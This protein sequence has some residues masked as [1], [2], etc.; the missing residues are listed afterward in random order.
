MSEK[1]ICL[2]MIYSTVF[3]ALSLAGI[4]SST[5]IPSG[6]YEKVFA[7]WM[8]KYNI[9]IGDGEFL[10]RLEIFAEN[11]ENIEAHNKMKSTYTLGLNA[12]SHMTNDEFNE[13]FHLGEYSKVNP[14]SLKKSA[15]STDESS[16]VSNPQAVDWR[17]T[18]GVVTPV[19]NQGNC[20][21]CWSFSATGGLE[22][23]YG[24]TYAQTSSWTGFSEQELVSCDKVDGGCNGGWMDDA[25]AWIQRNGGICS[26]SSY[27]YTSGNNG[28]DGSCAQSSCTNVANSKV[29]SWVDVTAG[30]V[31]ALETAVAKQPVSVAIQANQPAFQSYSGG[32]LTGRCG[33]NLDHGVLAVGYNNDAS[34]Y[35]VPYW[36]VKN[37]WGAGWGV[38]GYI[39]IEKSSA[40]LCGILD[41]ASYPLL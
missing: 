20:G 11:F 28:Q 23:I 31:S 22:G 41:A 39:Y 4:A 26:E 6:K 14:H 29:G 13:Y 16:N 30:S 34:I 24:Q 3:V 36:I 32:V 19:K 40:D 27:P 35:G 5:E 12:Y 18:A 33:N 1:H 37:S 38:G 25:F 15:L 7:E 2:N 9:K 8:Q 10:R 17:T 21:S